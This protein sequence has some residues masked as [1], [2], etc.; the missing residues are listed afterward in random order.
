MFSFTSIEVSR[1][2]SKYV[3]THNFIKLQNFNKFD[4]ILLISIY[5]YIYKFM[6]ICVYYIYIY[7]YLIR[8]YKNKSYKYQSISTK[9]TI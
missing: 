7:I 1:K 6:Y 8:P 2:L 3:L 9:L 5:I 4:K